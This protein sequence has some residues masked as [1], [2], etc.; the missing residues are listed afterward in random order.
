M[1]RLHLVR[2][3]AAILLVLWGCTERLVAQSGVS[4][5]LSQPPPNQLKIAD[6]WRIRLVNNT[7]NTYTVC[8][9]GT[10]DETA[11][12]LRLVDATTTTFTLPPGTKIVTGAE[13]QPIDATYHEER[14]KNVFLRTGQA[15]TGEYRIC[16]E[17][18]NECGTQVLATDC[19]TAV[20]QQLSPPILISP[21]DESIV[22]EPFPAFSWLPPSPLRAG[23]R[24]GYRIRI[25]E[26]LGRQSSYDAMQSNPAWFERGAIPATVFQYPISSRKFRV[27]GR[28][29]W[30]IIASEGDFPM[31]ESEIWSFIYKPRTEPD[32]G[33]D[34]RDDRGRG[35]RDT[36]GRSDPDPG[37]GFEFTR[38]KGSILTFL[39]P[40]GRKRGVSLINEQALRPGVTRVDIDE[41][42]KKVKLAIPP[43]LLQEL[44]RSCS[45]E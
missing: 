22:E 41:I 10:L 37:G 7:Q 16:V 2:M 4:V 26:M 43:A 20:V 40:I 3:I 28:Y 17:V 31:G 30:R 8:L 12:G 24:P 13:I 21:P 11:R 32:I 9:F 33:D 5:Q 44:L 27:G 18:R 29:A 23:Q 1:T 19:K 36:T 25:V 14:Y 38:R 35:G 34:G 39:D 45:G 6:L 15:P 42:T